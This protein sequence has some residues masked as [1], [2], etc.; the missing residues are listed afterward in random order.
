MSEPVASFDIFDT[1][2][3]RRVGAPAAVFLFAGRAAREQGLV[4][5]L[6]EDFARARQA[7][8]E[9]ARQRHPA[10]ETTLAEITGELAGRLG[11]G[12]EKIPALQAIELAEEARQIC[13][14]PG[15]PGLLATARE[16]SPRLLFIS[17]MYLPADFLR[18][19]LIEHGCWREGDGLY[20]SGEHGRAK[21]DGA[22]FTLLLAQENLSAA[23]LHHTGNYARSDVTAPRSLGIGATLRPA[24]NPNRYEEQ[25]EQFARATQGLAS[26]HAGASRLARLTTPAGTA[27]AGA[28]RDVAAGVAAPVLASY[29]RWVLRES[30]RRGIGRL[31][32]VAR[33]G[34]L[35]LQLARQ[36]A[37]QFHPT[38]ELRYLHGSRQAWHLPG[39]F[40]LGAAELHWLFS[41]ADTLSVATICARVNLPPAAI[42]APLAAAGFPAGRWEEN[43]SPRERAALRDVFKT[44][45]VTTLIAE[46]AAVAR[47]PLAAYLQQEGL[48]SRDRC[49][50]VDVGWHGQAQDSLAKVIT[51]AGWPAPAGF[52]FGLNSTS[53]LTGLGERHPW[54]FDRR[55]GAA[56]PQACTGLEALMEIFCTAG[57]GAT[58]GYARTAQG[59]EPVLRPAPAHLVA[60]GWPTLQATVAAYGHALTLA[61]AVEADEAA[62]RAMSG[63]VLR[64]FWKNPT[65]DEAAAW[66]AFSYEDDQ[67]SATRQ[68]LAA[69]LPWSQA[70]AILRHGR[71]GPHRAAWWQGPLQ[72]TPPGRGAVLRGARALRLAARNAKRLFP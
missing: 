4:D 64:L 17:D 18:A 22:L 15:A 7:A 2:L 61:P 52:Y 39:V 58:T 59:V 19:R 37:P 12:V 35:L 48:F 16:R 36:L 43:L 66:G 23:Q 71:L 1:V 33:D 27:A 28:I 25:L 8:E 21:R 56:E 10:R 54:F 60:W 72:L 53:G 6:P 68:P 70:A 38:A 44:P 51:A 20:V 50:L 69:P 34:W 42:A 29:V 30:R 5:I 45:T 41:A 40:S 47:V 65:H 3:T 62:V 9:T 11:F 57:H 46:Q 13:V 32:F 14:V 63:A 55:G 49:A 31:Y 67:M 24:A 26:L